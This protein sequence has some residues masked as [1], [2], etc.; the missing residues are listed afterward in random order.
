MERRTITIRG[1]VQ[2][3]GLRL[4]IASI[5]DELGVCGFVENLGNGS[6]VIECEGERQV[7]DEMMQQ[8]KET[9]EPVAIESMTMETSPAT[10]NM[11]GFHILNHD[12]DEEVKAAILAG[13][14]QLT[15]ISKTLTSMGQTL[16]SINKTQNTM[17]QTLTS[18]NKTQNTMGQTLTSMG[19]TLTSIN[20]TQNT[21]SQ[22]L[23]SMG[24]TL[25]SIN[26][27]QNTMSQTL[28]S[29]NKT[30]NTM[31]QTLTSI[32]NTLVS[33][34]SKLDKLLNNDAQIL[35]ILRSMRAGGMLQ[36][37]E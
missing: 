32:S 10:S 19:Q 14:A 9:P 17:G 6:V 2:R 26:K 22:T 7:L 24:Q 30:Q 33:M 29:I 4:K 28:T 11:S 21:M 16:T 15:T 3:V 34:N 36:I 35:E 25:T 23:T 5:A 13:T 31:S 12:V 1:R 18:I 27:T 20:K 37:T 8:I